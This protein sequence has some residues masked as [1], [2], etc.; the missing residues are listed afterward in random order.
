MLINIIVFYFKFGEKISCLH[1]IGIVLMVAC[2]LSISLEAASKSKE[3]EDFDREETMGLSQV[4]SSILA[5]VCALTGACL[6]S[7]KHVFIRMF[8]TNYSG[9]DMGVDSALLEFILFLF[10]LAP[11]SQ[12]LI[13][14]WKEI[15]VGSI[16]G[17]LFCL[18]R[19][20]IVIAI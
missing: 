5:I 13:I 6:M 2:I 16:S 14:G 10:L 17:I 4:T 8:K 9:V 11:L 3:D 1:I 19:I 20:T 15:A 7:T 12:Q 18:G